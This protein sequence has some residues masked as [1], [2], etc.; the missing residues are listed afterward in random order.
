MEKS[1]ENISQPMKTQAL[2]QQLHISLSQLKKVFQQYASTG[3]HEYFLAMKMD[4]ARQML[5][6]GES[7][8]ATAE[9]VGFD[10][11]NY[12]SAVFKRQVGITPGAYRKANRK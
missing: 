10:C 6:R 7:V 5:A 4:V 8:S 12:F 2:A 1:R 11:G 3:V 9:A